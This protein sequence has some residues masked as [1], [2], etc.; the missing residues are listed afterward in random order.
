V[1]L[2][3]ITALGFG[4]DKRVKPALEILNRKRKNDRWPLERVHPD[5]PSFA[6]GKGNRR[7]RTNPF[8]LE[9]VG[10]P[11]KWVTLTALKV[12]KRVAEAQ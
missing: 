6:W 5:P 2:D 8:A 11:S 9:V 1:G 12:Q 10:R 4:G 7:H 3:V